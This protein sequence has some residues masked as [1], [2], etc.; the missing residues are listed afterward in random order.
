MLADFGVYRV[1]TWRGGSIKVY[2]LYDNEVYNASTSQL[3]YD[4]GV[5]SNKQVPIRVKPRQTA[6]YGFKIH[7]E[8]TGYAKIYELEIFVESG[9]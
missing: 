6:N 2:I 7:V 8:G 1:D 4:S 9:R 3:A 5:L